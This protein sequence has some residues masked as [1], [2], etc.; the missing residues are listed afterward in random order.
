ML[1]IRGDCRSSTSRPV[2]DWTCW[3][4]VLA[5]CRE[6]YVLVDEPSL[7]CRTLLAKIPVSML[8]RKGL[9]N[10]M[11]ANMMLK[12]VAI[13]VVKT[14]L[15][16]SNVGSTDLFD[17]IIYFKRRAVAGMT[18]Q[19]TW[20]T[21]AFKRF[22]GLSKQNLQYSTCECYHCVNLPRTARSDYMED[23]DR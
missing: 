23:E 8:S 16:S 12:F 19:I 9:M 21:Y 11:H 13:C 18:L 20:F 3:N 6:V 7:G 17:A 14:M 4:K 10:D 2:P 15:R 1:V 5:Y 22:G